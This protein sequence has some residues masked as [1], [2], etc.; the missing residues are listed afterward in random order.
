[1]LQSQLA[2]Q[3]LSTRDLSSKLEVSSKQV[4]KLEAQVAALQETAKQLAENR[5]GLEG[6]MLEGQCWVPVQLL[7]W[8]LVANTVFTHHSCCM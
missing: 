4:L 2:A 5:N 3:Q 8:L 1:M 6:G 7:S